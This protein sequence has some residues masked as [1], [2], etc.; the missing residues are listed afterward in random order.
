[1]NKKKTKVMVMLAVILA[2]VIV[3][4]TTMAQA[5]PKGYQFKYNG[6]TVSVHGE[7]KNLIKKMGKPS[8]KSKTVSC[9]YKG[10]DIKYVYKNFTLVTYTNKKGG[11]EY[12]QSIKFTTNKVQTNEGLKIGSS[13]NTMLKKYGKINDNFGVYTYKKGKMKLSFTVKG[14]KITGIEYIAIQ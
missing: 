8:R 1:M 13:K 14:S 3:I 5:A 9:A 6:V 7:A 11:T 4:P 2:A 10:E 12:V